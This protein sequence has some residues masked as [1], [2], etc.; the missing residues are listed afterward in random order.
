MNY[1]VSC[2]IYPANKDVSLP[3]NSEEILAHFVTME[4][5]YF[6]GT[7]VPIPIQI[8]NLDHH[9]CDSISI[10]GS[11]PRDI[12]SEACL[13]FLTKTYFCPLFLA[14]PPCLI[15]VMQKG[16]LRV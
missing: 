9:R 1:S 15:A 16:S 6:T 7:F 10:N 8:D 14:S 11:K 4:R 13:L 5:Y 2:Q 12:K 3:M